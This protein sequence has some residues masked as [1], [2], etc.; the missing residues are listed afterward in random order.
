MA[1]TSAFDVLVPKLP[2]DHDL[3]PALDVSRVAALTLKEVPGNVS[4]LRV[5][6]LELGSDVRHLLLR[7]ASQ[8][9]DDLVELEEIDAATYS[10]RK[11][12]NHCTQEGRSRRRA[13]TVGDA[14]PSRSIPWATR[15]IRRWPTPVTL[16]GIWP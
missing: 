3:A 2:P 5:E 12:G 14:L 7:A 4:S 8:H 15:S 1:D 11:E 13:E 16:G 10:D 6:L 9:R